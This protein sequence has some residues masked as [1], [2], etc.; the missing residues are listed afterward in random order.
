MKLLVRAV[1]AWLAV[2]LVLMPHAAKARQ[3][4][5]PALKARLQ[6]ARPGGQ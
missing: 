5:R 4:P 2:V 1:A 3:D 6:F